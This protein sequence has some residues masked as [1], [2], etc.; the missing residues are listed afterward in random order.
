MNVYPLHA[1]SIIGTYQEVTLEEALKEGE[2]L[3]LFHDERVLV[4]CYGDPITELEHYFIPYGNYAVITSKLEDFD[5]H[6][7][8]LRTHPLFCLRKDLPILIERGK[9]VKFYFPI[10]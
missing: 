3:A 4:G 10:K 1:V 6:L 5:A 7:E 9:D 8:V 2:V